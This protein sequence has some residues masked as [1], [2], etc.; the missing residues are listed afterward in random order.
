ME[1]CHCCQEHKWK[2]TDVVNHHQ[3]DDSQK[4]QDGGTMKDCLP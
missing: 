3:N 1:T 4:Q 2:A